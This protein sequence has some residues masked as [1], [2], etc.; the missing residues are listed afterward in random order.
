MLSLKN[1]NLT[2]NVYSGTFFPALVFFHALC[3]F[4]A[5]NYF[6]LPCTCLRRDGASGADMEVSII[7]PYIIPQ[8]LV[9]FYPL[10]AEFNLTTLCHFQL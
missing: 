1:P 2:T 6:A 9:A 7:F 5:F 10:C 8:D 3:G 4:Q